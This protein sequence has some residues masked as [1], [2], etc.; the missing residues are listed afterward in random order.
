M[1]GDA[2]RF[3]FLRLVV[4][5]ATAVVLTNLLAFAV[6]VAP[7]EALRV[8]FEGSLSSGYGVGQILFRATPIV[9]TAVAARFALAAGLFNIGIEGQLGA[10]SLAVG[11]LGA[12][13]ASTGVASAVVVPLLVVVA[14]LVGAAVSSVPAV[15][16]ARFGASEVIAGIVMNQLVAQVVSLLLRLGL[17]LPGTTRTGSISEGARLTSLAAF[18]APLAGSPVSTAFVGALVLA[19]ASFAFLDRKSVV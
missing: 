9:I 13:L 16:R 2:L 11:A 8:A 18:I 15:L 17:A 4:A 12:V 7:R 14:M 19:A 1:N 10:A 3:G 5:I 6:G